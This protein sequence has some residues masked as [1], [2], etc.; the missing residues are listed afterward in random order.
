MGLSPDHPVSYVVN[1]IE[2]SGVIVLAVPCP[3][4]TPVEGLNASN[5]QAGAGSGYYS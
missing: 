1:A 2:R 3:T 4:E 5:H